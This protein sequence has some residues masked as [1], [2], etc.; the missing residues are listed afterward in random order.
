MDFGSFMS[1]FCVSDFEEFLVKVFSGHAMSI[2][3]YREGVLF[4]VEFDPY[5]LCVSVPS[6]RDSFADD[7]D[8]I[9]V[10]LAS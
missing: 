10:E 7:R 3:D 4:S 5:I 1:A 9:S 6:V 2:I 8:K